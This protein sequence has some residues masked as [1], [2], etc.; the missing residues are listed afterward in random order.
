MTDTPA[1]RTLYTWKS[2]ITSWS[3]GTVL[4]TTQRVTVGAQSW[5]IADLQTAHLTTVAHESRRLPLDWAPTT[6][7]PGCWLGLVGLLVVALLL[8][9][10]AG[11]G[12]PHAP[13]RLLAVL[14]FV[15]SAG[16]VV[17]SLAAT[18]PV[19][20]VYRLVLV[21][22]AGQSQPAVALW[23]AL[24]ERWYAE[25]TV[26]AIQEAIACAPKGPPPPFPTEEGGASRRSSR[27]GG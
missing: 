12:L 7:G 19:T 26:A 11:G 15:L 9:I 6:A 5:P 3:R 22:R 21:D 4:V 27:T 25:R 2:S 17:F 1:E 8:V 23:W 13:I 20:Q 14:L 24:D 10:D 16:G 18:M